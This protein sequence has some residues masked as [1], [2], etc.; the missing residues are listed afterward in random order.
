MSHRIESLYVFLVTNDQGDEGVAAFFNP[1]RNRL[2]PL[3]A[4]SEEKLDEMT[5][6][7]QGMVELNN[8][9]MRVVQ[10]TSRE[11]VAEILPAP[12]DQVEEQ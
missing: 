6:L 3:V 11:D 12:A 9:P 10:F 1:T 4:S 5:P 7:A 8:Q 2:E